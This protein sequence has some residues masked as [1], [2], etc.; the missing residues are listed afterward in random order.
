MSASAAEIHF[1]AEFVTFLAAAVGIAVVLLRGDLL[2]AAPTRT[3][4]LG[5][6]VLFGAAAFLHGA[7]LLSATADRP[8][9]FALRAAGLTGIAWAATQWAGPP[10]GRRLLWPGLATLALATVLGLFDAAVATSLLLAAGSLLV[11]GAVV[12]ASRRSIASRVAASA[13]ITLLLVVLVLAVGLS[14]VLTNTVQDQ[15]RV[16]L[17]T[18]AASEAKFVA[19]PVRTRILEANV[20]AV[21]VAVNLAVQLREAATRPEAAAALGR[22]LNNFSVTF[23]DSRP[24]AY[25]DVDGTAIATTTDFPGAAIALAG[26]PPVRQAITQEH[27]VGSVVLLGGKVMALGV[28]PVRPK[29]EG[30]ERTAGV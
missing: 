14:A 23:L 16:R 13:S 8:L 6:F 10:Q 20:A 1:A 18:R 2:T 5:G 19:D 25:I 4:L 15:A 27:K 12:Y 17:S 30:V 24:L 9:L 21:S 3:P 7:L 29:V 26:S 22:A 11:G 28:A